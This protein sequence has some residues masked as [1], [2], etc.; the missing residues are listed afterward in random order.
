MAM[1]KTGSIGDAG[2]AQQQHQQYDEILEQLKA[3]RAELS[4]L[5]A[6]ESE[7]RA[8]MQRDTELETYLDRLNRTIGKKTTEQHVAAAID[9]ADLRMDPCPYAVIDNFLPGR[10][11]DSLLRGIP[12]V[13]QFAGKPMG[14]QHMDVP[15]ALAPTYSQRIWAYMATELVPDV[16]APKVTEKFRAS[17]D[18]WIATNWP[19]LPPSTVELKGSGGRIM[20]RR[21][22][23]RI[24]PHRDPK[25]SFI[26]C[27]F[28]LARPGDNET[29]GTQLYAVESDREADTAAPYWI[30]DKQCRLVRDVEFRQNRLLVFLNSV[31]A[32]GAS[33]P[34][35]AEPAD[36]E[37]YIYQFRVGPTVDAIA[38]LKAMLPEE[39]Q[40]LWAGM[41]LV[42]Y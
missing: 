1:T 40:A 30:D 18:E 31:G 9:G 32:H 10:L 34:A 33:I 37:R 13:E 36:L 4:E 39:R 28:Y 15:F 38:K 2:V 14:K 22:G 21:R 11:Y 41:A 19:D 42:D 16:I 35:D 20:Y 26:T 8:I 7:L 6:R 29:W 23:Y 17:I 24:R 3:I 5:A 27:I 25:W 12:P